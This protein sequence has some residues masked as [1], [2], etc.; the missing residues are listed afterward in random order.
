M[1]VI[2]ITKRTW[3]WILIV[4]VAA[5]VAVLLLSAIGKPKAT[6]TDEAAQA[7]AEIESYELSVL[8]LRAR[9]LPVY[10]VAREDKAI[11]LTID[12]AWD[13]DK[14]EFILKL[15]KQEDVK[16]TFFLCGV[17]VKAYPDYVKRLAEEGH[18]I[19]NHSLTHPH[20]NKL[21]AEQIR[22]EISDLDDIIE[23]LTG[24]RCTLFRAPY[25][26]YNNT[27]VQTVRA[28]GYEI[29]QW[30][31]DVFLQYGIM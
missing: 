2:V 4:A 29:V 27:V 10:N 11:A 28:M 26:E 31:R 25:G 22:A 7:M 18:V 6:E 16:A 17:W 23:D 30:N 24:Q 20:M 8:P 12:A 13:T 5:I 14:T 15:L 1:P 3:K 19:A 21:S 9:E